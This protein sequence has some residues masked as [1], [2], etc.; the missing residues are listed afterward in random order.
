LV[1]L[2][3]VWATNIPTT[4]HVFFLQGTVTDAAI[5]AKV[6][7]LAWPVFKPKSY[8]L[9][10]NGGKISA[11]VE[12]SAHASKRVAADT[13]GWDKTVG[14]GV[15]GETTFSRALLKLPPCLHGALTFEDER[16]LTARAAAVVG[17]QGSNFPTVNVNKTE[18]RTQ[19]LVTEIELTATTPEDIPRSGVYLLDSRVELFRGNIVKVYAETVDASIFETV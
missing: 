2:E 3:E 15:S 11:E 8:N 19:D 14:V 1:E 7:A 18:T 13:E 9:V 10:A 12:V 5:R 16:T 6:S 4:Q 17:W